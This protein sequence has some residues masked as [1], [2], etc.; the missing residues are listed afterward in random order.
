MIALTRRFHKHPCLAQIQLSVDNLLSH[1]F[2]NGNGR[3]RPTRGFGVQLSG[4]STYSTQT[5]NSV[6][7]T[8][9]C[10]DFL[11]RQTN[12]QDPELF[13]IISSVETI[14][15]NAVGQV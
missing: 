13:K 2:E 6:E 10:V 15:F 12:L 1:Y 9:V 14:G 7:T 3:L 8:P 4:C 11:R 5:E